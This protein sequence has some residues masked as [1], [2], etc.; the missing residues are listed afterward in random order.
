SDPRL[1]ATR[2][3]RR[4]GKYY[5]SGEKWF[6]TTGDYADYLIVHAHVDGDPEKP[7]LFLVDKNL[8]GVHIHRAPKSMQTSASA[9][10]SS[11]SRMSS[12]IPRRC[13]AGSARASS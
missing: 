8:P 9:I 1:V 7:T 13:W 10:P 2:A 3:D 12:S 11:F 4:G 5:L 6:V